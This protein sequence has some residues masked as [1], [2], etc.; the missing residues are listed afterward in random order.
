MT[1]YEAIKQLTVDEMAAFLAHEAFKTVKPIFD[2]TGFGIEEQ[3][4]WFL[5]KNWLESEVEENE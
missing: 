1:Y 2:F 5:R 4:I 3:F